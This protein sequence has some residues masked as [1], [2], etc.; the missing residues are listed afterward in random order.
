MKIAVLTCSELPKG[1]PYDV[2]IADKLQENNVSTV[3]IVWESFMYLSSEEIKLFDFV[4][5]RTTW[6]YCKKI[7]RFNELLDILEKHN[8]K[9]LNPVDI[10]RWNMDKKY[11]M[12]F[13]E[14]GMDI[15]PTIFN[16]EYKPKI[17][18][19]IT[20][21]GWKRFVLKP[22]ISAGSYHT[23]VI[24]GDDRSGFEEFIEKYYVNRP[25]LLQEFIPEIEEGEISTI[26][27]SCPGDCN[28]RGFTYSTTKIPKEGDY[29]VQMNFGGSYHITSV[30]DDI[31]K[32]SR[33]LTEKFEGRLLYQRLDGVW[34]DGKFM[35]MELELIEPDL[36]L[37]LHE[38]ALDKL[39]EN[40]VSYLDCNK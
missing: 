15:I 28:K 8:V 26:T 24:D 5:I 3:Y 1:L 6:D 19:E 13:E 37:N 11:L 22:M 7:E 39:V 30:N 16:F 20:K 12:E 18:D 4:W 27:L 31:A 32:I 34:R 9:V 35:I 10:V 25:F 29:R 14:D 17:F 38:K 40:I 23:F 21:R 33:K 36:Y 2:V